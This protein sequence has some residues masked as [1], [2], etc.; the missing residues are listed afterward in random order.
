MQAQGRTVVDTAGDE[1]L[2]ESLGWRFV[3]PSLLVTALTH[4]SDCAEYGV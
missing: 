3:D 2:Q 4:R 1:R